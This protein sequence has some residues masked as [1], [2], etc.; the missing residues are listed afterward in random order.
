LL[1]L[2]TLV[3]LLV[4]SR[5][6]AEAPPSPEEMMAKDK[7]LIGQLYQALG[8]AEL[9]IQELQQA[10]SEAPPVGPNEDKH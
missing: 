10:K 2:A 3:L 4:A 5:A 1:K 7:L 9:K 8:A 6:M